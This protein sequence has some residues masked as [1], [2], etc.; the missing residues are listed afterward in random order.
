MDFSVLKKSDI[1]YLEKLLLNEEGNLQ[2]ISYEYL[3][4]VP[5]GDISQFCVK[6]GFYCLPTIELLT[7][8]QE[9]IGDQKENTIEIGAGHGAISRFLGIKAVDNYM[10]ESPQ[11]KAYYESLK[12]TIVP[13]GKHVEKIDANSA[14][15]KYKPKVVI[16][17]FCTHLY[18]PREHW[19]EGNQFGINE[20]KIINKVDKYIHIGNEK[21]HGK[22]PIL[23][24]QHRSSKAEWLLS[25]SQNKNQNVIWVWEK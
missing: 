21:V 7:F 13:Y 25:R 22:K 8:L 14:V 4:D 23:K 9:E 5:Q 10:Q 11:I 3:K 18:N 19:R 16:G 6:Y 20:Q 24:H 2:I 12:Q 15:Q 1:S 17:A